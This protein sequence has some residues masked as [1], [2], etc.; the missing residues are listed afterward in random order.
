MVLPFA[1]SFWIGK[2][3]D[4]PPSYMIPSISTNNS[5]GHITRTYVTRN[6]HPEELRVL[7]TLSER[8]ALYFVADKQNTVETLSLFALTVMMPVTLNFMF[9]GAAPQLLKASFSLHYFLKVLSATMSHNLL[10][11]NI[12][13]FPS[14]CSP[15]KEMYLLMTYVIPCIATEKKIKIKHC[16]SCYMK[17]HSKV[18][19]EF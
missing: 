15:F 11:H 10:Q 7:F 14:I 1:F 16:L 5:S 17:L 2:G 8:D 6:V 12:P 19:A 9:Q 18:T 3:R 4:W 13:L